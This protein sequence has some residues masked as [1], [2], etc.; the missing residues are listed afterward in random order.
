MTDE[1]YG[2]L[3]EVYDWLVP[4]DLLDPEASV[5]MFREVIDRLRPGARVLDCAAGT[6]ELAVGL[7]LRGCDVVAS[8]A[9]SAMIERTQA[10]AERY[11]VDLHAVTCSWS[12]LE[13]HP[14][15]Q[16]FDAVFCVGNSITHAPGRAARQLALAAMRH[17]LRDD[18]VLVL[19]S[20]NWERFRADRPTLDVGDRLISRAGRQA[21]VV[22]AWTIPDAWDQPHHLHIAVAILGDDG[23]LDTRT[24]RLPFWP[25]R[26]ETLVEDLR[27]VGLRPA[28][29]GYSSLDER[30]VITAT[31][32]P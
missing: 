30:Y 5:G 13:S 11:R 29:T 31:L 28:S 12:Q 7:S 10:L 3:A 15:A 9:S 27:A 18:G 21:I 26:H 1:M 23:E 16:D 22:H 17:V 2:T 24:E 25:F 19:G 14:W 32:A 20:R 8:D 6:G 4:D